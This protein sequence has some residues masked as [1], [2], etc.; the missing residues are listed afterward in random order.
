MGK[1]REAW[2]PDTHQ[3]KAKKHFMIQFWR[4]QQSQAFVNSFFFATT[5]ALLLMPYLGPHITDITHNP[6]LT[7]L[8]LFWLVM[9]LILLFGY[10]FDNIWKLWKEQVTVG[11]ERN[12]YA[13][14]KLSAK[15]VVVWRHLH[16]PILRATGQVHQAELM[17]AWL[18]AAVAEDERLASD[19]GNLEG[20]LRVTAGLPGRLAQPAQP[21]IIGGGGEGIDL[22]SRPLDPAGGSPV[23]PIRR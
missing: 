12:P 22:L 14:E 9:G 17:E 18:E 7:F 6:L 13:L 5:L 16:L 10:A 21:E 4:M 11:T 20:W 3:S 15:E 8:G 1:K 2:T 23:S 19:V